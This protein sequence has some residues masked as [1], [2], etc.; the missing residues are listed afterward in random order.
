MAIEL[1]DVLL[2]L[3]QKAADEQG[4]FVKMALGTPG[5]HVEVATLGMKET[6]KAWRG[7]S[8]KK[9]EVD[10]QGEMLGTIMQKV[11]ECVTAINDIIEGTPTELIDPL[12]AESFGLEEE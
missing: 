3:I 12:T 9:A 5:D 8:V 4:P 10:V 1:K 2:L 7:D 6:G 11:N